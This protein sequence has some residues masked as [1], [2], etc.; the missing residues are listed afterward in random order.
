[1]KM[2][3]LFIAGVAMLAISSC[4]KTQPNA[5]FSSSTDDFEAYIP[6]QFTSCSEDGAEYNWDFGNGETSTE[7]NPSTTFI[8]EGT[9]LVK[10]EVVSKNGKLRNTETML[11]E[12]DYT[13]NSADAE[14]AYQLNNTTATPISLTTDG[15]HTGYTLN[16]PFMVLEFDGVSGSIYQVSWDDSF[17]GSDTYDLDIRVSVLN[18]DGSVVYINSQ[19]SGYNTPETFTAS[20]TGK[21]KIL[22]EPYSSGNTGTFGLYVQQL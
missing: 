13:S 17:Q 15:T 4:Q 21:I 11:V 14:L 7:E 12:V 16:D 10:L 2:K 5:C 22:V 8:E 6:V 19:D 18:A 3:D 20:E 9:Y 1:M